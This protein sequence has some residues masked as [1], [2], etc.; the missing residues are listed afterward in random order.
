[1]TD[2]SSSD[3]EKIIVE[4]GKKKRIRLSLGD[5]KELVEKYKRERFQHYKRV[6]GLPTSSKYL[7]ELSCKKFCKANKIANDA[8]LCKWL[9]MDRLAQLEDWGGRND[10][11]KCNYKDFDVGVLDFIN[12]GLTDNP[13]IFIDSSGVVPNEYGA[14]AKKQIPKDTVIGYYSGQLVNIGDI[15]SSYQFAINESEAID[16]IDFLS[17]HG[18]YINDAGLSAANVTIYRNT[19][20]TENHQ[21]FLRIKTLKVIEPNEELLT[22]YGED[23]WRVSADPMHPNDNRKQNYLKLA[24]INKRKRDVISSDDESKS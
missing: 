14:F 21:H 24:D 12:D 23:Y 6:A 16:S 4:K 13:Y 7:R 5:K 19:R 11:S 18:R 20:E 8:M 15:F 17:C 10:L 3:G 1:M 2:K 9:N 22:H